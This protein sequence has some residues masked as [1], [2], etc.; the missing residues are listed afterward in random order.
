[1]SGSQSNPNP[2]LA[3]HVICFGYRWATWVLT[4]VWLLLQSRLMAFGWALIAT[5]AVTIIVTLFAQRYVRIASHTPALLSLDIVL[6]VGLLIQTGGWDSPFLLFSYSSLVLPALLFRWP[7]GVM[8]GL[9][10]VA[11]HQA[12]LTTAGMPLSDQIIENSYGS[13]M[14]LLNMILP[15]VFGVFCWFGVDR[16]RHEAEERLEQ[17]RRQGQSPLNEPPAHEP[18]LDSLRFNAPGRDAERRRAQAAPDM[19]FAQEL[20]RTRTVEPGVEEL[21]RVLFMPLSLVETELGP[22]FELL[23]TRFGQHTGIAT[24]VAS[25]GRTRA[26]SQIHRELLVRL[27]REALLNI[28]QHAHAD[29]ANLTVHYDSTGVTLLIQDD[30]VGLLDGTHERPRLHALRAMRYRIAECGGRLDIFETEGGGVTVRATMPL[31]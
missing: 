20:T 17:R 13:L 22:S 4:A 3:D 21:R 23:A 9:T 30:G 16:L 8:A 28:Q 29:V 10:F 27:A 25:I 26:V 1:M 2:W 18:R 14:L 31:E 7:G 12:G 15:P 11:L 5:L 6:A 19:L 24:R